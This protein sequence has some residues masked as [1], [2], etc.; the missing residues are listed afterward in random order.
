[1]AVL[2]PAGDG[3]GLTL[4]STF[5]SSTLLSSLTGLEVGDA[6]DDGLAVVTGE[7][8]TAGVAAGVVL[9]GLLSVAAEQAPKNA[10]IAAKTVSRIDLLIFFIF[11]FDRSQKRSFRAAAIES[12]AAPAVTSYTAGCRDSPNSPRKKNIEGRSGPFFCN[13]ATERTGDRSKLAEF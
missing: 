4:V 8:V 5:L 9:T 13:T 2:F 6:V 3:A 1:M 11:L 7:A 12:E 10:A